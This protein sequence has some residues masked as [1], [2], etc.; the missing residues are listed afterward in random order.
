MAGHDGQSSNSIAIGTYAY[1]NGIQS[2]GIGSY[3]YANTGNS[4]VLNAT[5]GVLSSVN[6][7]FFVKPIRTD[8]YNTNIIFYNSSSGE[9]TYNNT[10]NMSFLSTITSNVQT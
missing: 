6:S 4:I 10:V 1:S 5:G 8:A 2:I 3:A 7:G 9:L